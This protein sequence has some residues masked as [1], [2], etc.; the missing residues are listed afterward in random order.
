MAFYGDNEA[1][2]CMSSILD[3]KR[4][5]GYE[6]PNEWKNVDHKW[7]CNQRKFKKHTIKM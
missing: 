3:W 2:K 1:I 7:T 5:H 4:T 6:I